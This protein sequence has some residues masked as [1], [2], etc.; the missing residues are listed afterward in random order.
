MAAIGD[1]YALH[2]VCTQ[3]QQTAYN[4]QHWQVNEV[5]GGAGRT[6]AQITLFFETLY[7]PLYKAVL[8][9]LASF[10]GVRMQKIWPLPALIPVISVISAGPGTAGLASLPKQTCGFFNRKGLLAGRTR[11]SRQYIPFPD[12]DD[13]LNATNTPSVGYMTRLG[14]IAGAALTVQ[15]V[16]AGADS[17]KL[18]PVIY[19]RATHSTDQLYTATAKVKWATQRR[20]GDFGRPNVPP[21]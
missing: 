2:V 14:A 8:T 4:I 20:R 1:I 19:H 16:A 15:T 9:S 11:I 10:W 21:A 13:N 3:Q 7:A 18:A 5:P 6:D 17:V 12:E